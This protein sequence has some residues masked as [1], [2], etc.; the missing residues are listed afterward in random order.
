MIN[1]MRVLLL[2]FL[3]VLEAGLKLLCVKVCPKEH[4]EELISLL[5]NKKQD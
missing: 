3:M 5:Y 4:R 2:S 1:K